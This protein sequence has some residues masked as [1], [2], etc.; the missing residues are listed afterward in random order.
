MK[1]TNKLVYF[2]IFF[3]DLY[4]SPL[5]KKASNILPPSS[6]NAGNKLNMHKNKL[7][8]DK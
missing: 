8:A 2:S 6:G 3:A 4:K 5:L 1:D 7:N